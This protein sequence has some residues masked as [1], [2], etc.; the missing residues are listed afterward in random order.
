M[1]EGYLQKKLLL[2]TS[3]YFNSE[4]ERTEATKESEGTFG[5]NS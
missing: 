3:N 1:I 5:K 4:K 2:T